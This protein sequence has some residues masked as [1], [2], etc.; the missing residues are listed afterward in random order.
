MPRPLSTTVT[1]TTKRR[2][3]K[4]TF[5]PDNQIFET[6]EF[7]FDTL[8]QRLRELAFLNAGVTITLED[9]REAA[10]SHRF[11]YDGGI[12]SFVEHLNK[13]KANVNDKPIYMRGVK[14]GIDA[15]IALQW[16]DGYSELIFSFA[17]NINTHE[18]GTHLSGFRSALTRTLN[19]FARDKGHLK[20]RDD[21]LSGEDVREG[22]TAVISAKLADPQ[23]EGQ[24]KTKLGNP[25]MAGF[26]ESVV[27]AKL[28]EFLEEN[29]AEGMSARA[30]RSAAGNDSGSIP[31]QPTPGGT[32]TSSSASSPVRSGTRRSPSG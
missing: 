30:A 1:G 8:A 28:A 9:E 7:S 11:H 32:C 23:F 15:E 29:P 31:I 17:N 20:E 13:N 26:V 3:T 18:G 14:D 25:G 22:L 2:G 24:T 5:K 21:N 27:N 19:R 4:V 12:V 16:N 10:K 6:T